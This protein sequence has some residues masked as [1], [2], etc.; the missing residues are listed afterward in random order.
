[1]EAKMC[2]LEK[3]IQKMADNV[4][5]LLKK[6]DM[7]KNQDSPSVVDSHGPSKRTRAHS[8]KTDDTTKKDEVKAMVE[9]MQM[10]V[11]QALD[12]TKTM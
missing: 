4:S 12:L 9:N 2:N 11:D 7:D 3:L 5:T 8:K 1:M 6:L 10:L